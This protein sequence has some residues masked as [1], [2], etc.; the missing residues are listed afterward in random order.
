MLKTLSFKLASRIA[1]LAVL[2]SATLWLNAPVHAQFSCFLSQNNNTGGMVYI[3]Y[4]S[5]AGDT[6]WSCSGGSCTSD[7]QMDYSAGQMCADAAANGCPEPVY[8]FD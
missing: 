6:L 7:P 5:S 1:C 8:Y 3:S 2:T 4:G